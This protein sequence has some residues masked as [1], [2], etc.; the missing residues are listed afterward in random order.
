MP[1]SKRCAGDRSTART[2]PLPCGLLA[3]ITAPSARETRTH[4]QCAPAG[5]GVDAPQTLK[6]VRWRSSEFVTSDSRRRRVV[7]VVHVLPLA[8]G[9]AVTGDS[10]TA[11]GDLASLVQAASRPPAETLAHSPSLPATPHP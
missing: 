8:V 3:G 1:L 10:H 2:N 7:L 9:V 4:H 5:Q 6:L 11:R